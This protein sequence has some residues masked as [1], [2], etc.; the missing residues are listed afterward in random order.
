MSGLSGAN[1]PP[2]GLAWLP[3]PDRITSSLTGWTRQHWIALA[4][5]LLAGLAPYT[6]EQGARF[7]LPGRAS[8]SGRVCD[9]LE[10]YARSSLVAAARIAATGGV[11]CDELIARYARGL[12]AGALPGGPESWPRITDCSQQMVEAAMVAISLHESR[13]WL[14][15]ALD[16]RTRQG[17][18]EWLSGFVGART[19]DNNWRLFLVIA[20]EFLASVGALDDRG[21]IDENLERI[22]DWYR[23]NGWY[24]DGDGQHFDYYNGF[25]MHTYPVLWTRIADHTRAHHDPGIDLDARRD[26]YHSRISEH[27]AALQHFVGADGAPVLHGR[28]TTYRMAMLAPFWTAELAGCSPLLPGRTR[29]LASGVARHFVEHGVPDARGLLSLGWYDT[30]L[31]MTQP[32]SGPGSPY[33]ASKAFLGLLLGADHPVWT[34]REASLE[35]DTH[36]LVVALPAPGMLVH[37][38]RDDGIVRVVNHGAEHLGTA[39]AGRPDGPPDPNYERYAYSSRTSPEYA[40]TTETPGYDNAVRLVGPDGR[41][42]G[43]GRIHRLGLGAD[44]AASWSP[45]VELTQPSSEARSRPPGDVETLSGDSEAHL[46][47]TSIVHGRYELRCLRLTGG[48]AG[49]SQLTVGGY[50]IADTTPP[51]GTSGMTAGV[52]WASVARTDGTVSTVWGLAGFSTAGLD[53]RIG[54]SAVGPTSATP[55][56]TTGPVPRVSVLLVALGQAGPPPEAV[57]IAVETTVDS[58]DTGM[59]VRL[60]VRLPGSPFRHTITWTVD[61]PQVSRTQ[62]ELP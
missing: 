8:W 55:V 26:R 22:E 9:G 13:R 43:R 21:Q 62:M 60:T 52:P 39:V 29:R 15:D 11:G 36:D 17:V 6:S 53:R 37:S 51:A 58:D 56:L 2:P 10:A 31:P 27:V 18:V 3:A 48:D 49:G 14:W 24:T 7:D 61:G 23:G 19:W 16:D 38:T 41:V 34:D 40:L 59:P 57:A 54:A 5:H 42:R 30:F 28:S 1:G 33:W 47:V 44:H 25:V 46:E 45:L 20:Q 12:T 32:Y 50:A 4:D 35:G